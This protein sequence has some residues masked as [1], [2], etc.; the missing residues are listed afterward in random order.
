MPDTVGDWQSKL[1]QDLA[2][3][4]ETAG[5]DAQVL[6]AHVL[7]RSRSWVLAHPEAVLSAA[8]K[9]QLDQALQALIAGAALP[10][11]LGRWEFYSLDFNVSPHVL[12][13]RPETELLVEQALAW[14]GNH[15]GQL[16]ALDL[17]AGSGCIA[18]SLLAHHP[19]LRA[20]AVDIS[21]EAITVAQGNAQKHAVGERINFVVSDL[22][23]ALSGRFDLICA[24]LPYIP[25]SKM[26]TLSV[27]RRE[28]R[29]ALDGGVDGL[30]L[31][32]R[33]LQSAPTQL[34]TPGLALVEIEATQGRAV[35]K[36]ARAFFPIAQVDLISDLAG[37][38]RLIRIEQR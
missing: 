3:S 26:Q 15:P 23:S 36:L 10:Y 22:L 2:F 1:A 37:R 31:I 12:I 7:N 24:N 18:V 25:I 21:P 32:R 13:P 30:D 6:L 11:I 17:G 5:L 27:A 35:Q 38:D 19:A 28:P 16:T 33:F 20:I 9:Q 4:S 8:Q 14:L 29:L 34:A